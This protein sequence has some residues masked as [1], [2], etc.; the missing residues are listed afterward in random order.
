MT[1]I[2]Y[3]QNLEDVMLC[4]ALKDIEKGFYIDV[5]ACDPIEGSV[6]RAF[7]ERGWRGINIEPVQEYFDRLVLDRPEDINLMLAA[8]DRNGLAQF[9][10]VPGTGLS[11]MDEVIADRLRGDGWDVIERRIPCATLTEICD[12][13]NVDEVH[14]L[15]IDV[16]GTEKSVLEGLDL[17]RIRPWIVVVEATEPLSPALSFGDWEPFLLVRDYDF[18]YFDGVNR[19]Y[20]AR[21]RGKLKQAFG[22]P[23][24]THDSFM[25]YSEWK[26]RTEQEA[27]QN[28]VEGLERSRDRVATELITV[29]AE[30]EALLGQLEGLEQARDRAAAELTTVQ[31]ERAALC[32]EVEEL[33]SSL[34][35]IRA[36]TSWRITAPLR[37]AKQAMLGIMP[38]I[39][40]MLLNSEH[41]APRLVLQW[42]GRLVRWTAQDRR[43]RSLGKRLLDMNP[44][45]RARVDRLIFLERRNIGLAADRGPQGLLGP[46]EAD[47]PQSARRVLVELEVAIEK[48]TSKTKL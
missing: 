41:A 37:V 42:V 40:R 44:A 25:L 8:G 30:R 27:L 2:S 31:A 9:F 43:L 12:V 16:E 17:S 24:N 19:F 33:S 46:G 3:A 4:R 18:V 45:L 26:A 22:S 7:H 5:G 34:K 15:K 28:Q 6:T 48:A 14:F 23:P 29:Q 39:R 11:T 36:S 47:L 35:D 1:F 13:N 10:E 38:W 21:E 20:V 32:G